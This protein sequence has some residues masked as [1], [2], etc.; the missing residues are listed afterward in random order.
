MAQNPSSRDGSSA[1]ANDEDQ[2]RDVTEN[3]NMDLLCFHVKDDA[4][5]TK[6]LAVNVLRAHE[7]C[8]YSDEVRNALVSVG[9]AGSNGVVHGTFSHRGDLVAAV[10]L[11]AWFYGAPDSD[12]DRYLIIMAAGC[13]MAF[14]AKSDPDPFLVSKGSWESI[15]LRA[16]PLYAGGRCERAARILKGPQKGALVDIV[17]LD[18][19]VSELNPDH[20]ENRL[21][22][23]QPAK[24]RAIRK[25]LLVDDS[26]TARKQAARIFQHAGLSD[27]QVFSAPEDLLGHLKSIGPDNVGIVV[28]DLEMD[29]GM[30]GEGLIKSIRADARFAGLPVLVYSGMLDDHRIK[31]V[32][33]YGATDT[34]DK[35]NP[36]DLVDKINLHA[37]AR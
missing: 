23:V 18:Q 29:R 6:F 3:A 17:D 34:A 10:D 30:G 14:L 31:E 19:L 9:K 11:R 27:V 7:I 12:Y 25:I 21:A 2:V 13:S 5:R 8:A 1:F 37:L 16:N 33:D 20:F 26:N 15:D 24:S 22:M 32:L 35:G 36:Q 4:G 28:T